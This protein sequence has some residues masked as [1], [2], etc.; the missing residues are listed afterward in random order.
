M[1]VEC[2][3]DNMNYIKITQFDTA[4]GIGIGTVLWVA[5]CEH[6]C[7]QCH[8]PQT[9]NP[10]NGRKFTDETLEFL[11]KTLEPEYIKRLTFS[12]GDPLYKNNLTYVTGI[13]MQVKCKFPNKAIWLYTGYQFEDINSFPILDY[14]DVLVD[15]KFMVEKKDLNLLYK[16]SSNQRVIDVKSTLEQG[17]VILYKFT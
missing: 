16:G 1:V 6:S 9:H 15:G 14:V 10:N 11:L 8:N 13:A 4:N 2:K 12:G 3:G 17:K 7:P 5:G